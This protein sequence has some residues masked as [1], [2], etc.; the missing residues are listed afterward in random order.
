MHSALLRY[1][2]LHCSTASY[3][4]TMSKDCHQLSMATI[5]TDSLPAIAWDDGE[6][7]SLLIILNV[8]LIQHVNMPVLGEEYVS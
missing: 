4:P 1:L 2:F 6:T 5:R 8:I 7:H 3:F